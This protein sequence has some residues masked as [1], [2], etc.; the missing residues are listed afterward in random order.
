METTRNKLPDRVQ[1][2]F[3]KLSQYLDTRLLFY[4]SVQRSDYFPGSSDIDVDIFTDNVDSTIA[5]MQHFLHVKRTSFKKIVWKLSNNAKMVYGNKIMYTDE[6][7]QFNAE[8]SIYDNKFKDDVL[9]MH[10]KKTVLPFY[11]SF[12]LFFIK[13]LYYDLHLIQPEY[14]RYLKRKILSLGLGMPEDQF[15]VLNVKN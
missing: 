13:K 4:G 9:Q 5:K 6:E 10:L 2:F 11:V 15:I 1:E 8:F 3:N 12:M 7:S 14:Y